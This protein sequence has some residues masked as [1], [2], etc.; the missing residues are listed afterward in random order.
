MEG[1]VQYRFGGR[2]QPRSEPEAERSTGTNGLPWLVVGHS[3]D[4][5]EYFTQ[6]LAAGGAAVET[7][8]YDRAG[9]AIQL[10][11]SAAVEAAALLTHVGQNPEVVICAADILT[12]RNVP[13]VIAGGMD[14]PPVL[15]EMATLVAFSETGLRDAILRRM[16][17]HIARR[18]D[19]DRIAEVVWGQED[20][21]A[22]I[23]VVPDVSAEEEAVED[24]Y[25]TSSF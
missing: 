20:P 17:E 5:A 3:D 12:D 15:Q 1:W 23:P 10:V 7:G 16:P 8:S 24:D 2:A 11:A 4:G 18:M 21:Y 6:A 19:P 14:V 9:D 25:V 22:P 13:L